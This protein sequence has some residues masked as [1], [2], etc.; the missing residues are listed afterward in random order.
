MKDKY[1]VSATVL[2]RQ[3]VKEAIKVVA[4]KCKGNFEIPMSAITYIENGNRLRKKPVRASYDYVRALVYEM[5]Q[6]K[7]I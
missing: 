1:K 2:K 7:E 3:V 5:I 6:A 4:P